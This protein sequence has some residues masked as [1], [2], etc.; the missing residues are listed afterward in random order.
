MK[1]IEIDE[2]L[3]KSRRFK[4]GDRIVAN[5]LEWKCI[6]ENEKYAIFAESSN[7]GSWLKLKNLMCLFN[8]LDITP[9]FDDNFKYYF[10]N[11]FNEGRNVPE[12][13]RKIN[14]IAIEADVNKVVEKNIEKEELN[15]T[16]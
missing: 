13:E 6:A 5:E 16:I 1:K 2:I 11:S 7:E 10:I 8:R 9:G 14:Y 15:E 4:L 3:N 12:E